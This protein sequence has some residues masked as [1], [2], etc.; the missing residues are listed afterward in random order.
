ML[1]NLAALLAKPP[2]RMHRAAKA[3]EDWV[4]GRYVREPVRPIPFCRL[5]PVYTPK[6]ASLVVAGL[7]LGVEG[8]S[9]PMGLEPMPGTVRVNRPSDKV[10][11]VANPPSAFA[12]FVGEISGQLMG[13]HGMAPGVA[14]A[15]AQDCWHKMLPKFRD[16]VERYAAADAVTSV[17]ED[18]GK[19]EPLGLGVVHAR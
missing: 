7:A 12:T 5:G 6:S 16:A 14:L 10:L 17:G 1:M 15:T 9:Q 4:S 18:D 2:Y 8:V 13:A 11:A 3:L 19:F